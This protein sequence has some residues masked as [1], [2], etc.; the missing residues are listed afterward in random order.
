MLSVESCQKILNSNGKN[1]THEEIQKIREF[2]YLL[3]EIDYEQ[4]KEI[5]K[6]QESSHLHTSFY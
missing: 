3:G 5:E 2:L 6:H 1:Y 4:F